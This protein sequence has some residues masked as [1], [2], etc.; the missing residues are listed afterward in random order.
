MCKRIWD[1]EADPVTQSHPILSLRVKSGKAGGGL[2]PNSGS[3]YAT[4]QM[5]H[6]P[7]TTNPFQV[8]RSITPP[9]WS[10]RPGQQIAV[11]S[12]LP[13]NSNWRSLVL[14]LPRC[15]GETGD[16]QWQSV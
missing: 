5:A 2:V 7:S 8:L 11:S 14:G 15:P 10:S 16:R 9:R 4:V 12:F 3:G 1:Q 6:L 13:S